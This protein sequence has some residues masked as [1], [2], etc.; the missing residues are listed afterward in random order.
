MTIYAKLNIQSRYAF[1]RCSA[2]SAISFY[3][4]EEIFIIYQSKNIL[5]SF[6]SFYMLNI[7]LQH[8]T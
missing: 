1:F 8:V 6:S 2:V 7:P 5:F 4:F 3:I